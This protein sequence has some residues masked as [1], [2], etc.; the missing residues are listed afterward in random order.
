VS[1]LILHPRPSENDVNDP[2]RWPSWKK[3]V[4]F[5]SVCAFTFLTNYAIGG[6]APAF[7]ILSLEFDKTMAETS[8]LL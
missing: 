1:E 4:A 8:D 7:Y 5:T 6:M 2:L 3:H